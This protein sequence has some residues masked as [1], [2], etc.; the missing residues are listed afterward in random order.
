MSFAQCRYQVAT[1]GIDC[2]VLSQHLRSRTDTATEELVLSGKRAGEITGFLGV[3]KVTVQWGLWEGCS[4]RS[5]A[6]T[7]ESRGIQ[8]VVR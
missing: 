1:V 4:G 8:T 6:A 7:G 2:T 3:L 5:C